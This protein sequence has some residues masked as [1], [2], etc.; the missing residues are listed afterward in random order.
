MI[1]GVKVG[2]S[3]EWMRRRLEAVGLRPINNVVDVTNY[4][5]FETGQPLHAFDFA[6]IGGGRIVVR[7][8]RPRREAD[9]PS[10]AAS[11]S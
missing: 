2:P 6:R 7:D 1:R 5:M 4:V 10:T 9:R 3:P 8:G 11:A